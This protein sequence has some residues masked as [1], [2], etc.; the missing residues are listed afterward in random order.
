MDIMFLDRESLLHIVDT[1]TRF[2]AAAFLG[3]EINQSVEG[4]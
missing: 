2:S 4:R 1:A 3:N